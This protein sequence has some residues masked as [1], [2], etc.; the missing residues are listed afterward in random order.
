MLKPDGWIYNKWER[1]PSEE[2]IIFLETLFLKLEERLIVLNL[3]INEE[4]VH[5]ILNVEE[6]CIIVNIIN[7]QERKTWCYYYGIKAC[8]PGIVMLKPHFPTRWYYAHSIFR[9]S[10]SIDLVIS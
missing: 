8:T 1:K 5:F 9:S 7:I 4:F 6:T 2:K 10:L 3:I